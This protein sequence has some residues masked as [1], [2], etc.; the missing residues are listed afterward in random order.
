MMGGYGAV[1]IIG[2]IWAGTTVGVAAMAQAWSRWKHRR[3]VVRMEASALKTVAKVLEQAAF[4]DFIWYNA[5]GG[6]CGISG[7]TL[8]AR[9]RQELK[10]QPSHGHCRIDVHAPDRLPELERVGESRFCG[11]DESTMTGIEGQESRAQRSRLNCDGA[12]YC[13]LRR[14]SKKTKCEM[15]TSLLTFGALLC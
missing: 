3:A 5:G 11:M 2:G 12:S 1:I 13:P 7:E 10:E 15:K 9:A 8:A 4:E 14:S 6:P